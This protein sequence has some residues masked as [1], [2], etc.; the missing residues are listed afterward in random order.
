MKIRGLKEN[1]QLLKIIKHHKEPFYKIKN[2][3]I[4]LE[5]F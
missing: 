2:I 4:E 5:S 1:F 3:K